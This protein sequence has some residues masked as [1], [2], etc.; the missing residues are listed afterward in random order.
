MRNNVNVQVPTNETTSYTLY[1]QGFL[2]EK[3][4]E[5]KDETTINFKFLGG[6]VFALF[7]TFSNF[8]RAYLATEWMN[9]ADGEPLRLPGIDAP[10]FVLYTARG[11]KIDELK[12]ALHILSDYN[13]FEMPIEFWQMLSNQIDLYGSHRTDI[14]YIYNRFVTKRSE[15]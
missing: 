9:E 11:R 7:Y 3:P 6:T 15:K 4:M 1:A 10:L 5:S 2:I 14:F 13:P 8:R 12:H